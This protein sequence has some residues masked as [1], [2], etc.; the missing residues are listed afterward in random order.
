M[1]HAKFRLANSFIRHFQGFINLC[2][3]PVPG[4]TERNIALGHLLKN[5]ITGDYPNYSINYS[6]VLVTKGELESAKDASV[7][8]KGAGVLSF[9]WKNNAD[10]KNANSTDK[11]ILVVYHEGSDKLHFSLD[12]ATR[13]QEHASFDLDFLSGKE[14]H[15][16]LSF[17]AW[18]QPLVAD[19]VYLGRVKLLWE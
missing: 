11:T 7:V 19:S 3:Q 15:V 9:T 18:L 5:A 1:Q 8:S 4:K 14:V 2:F 16:W 12:Q 17:R 13:S 6:Q 10:D